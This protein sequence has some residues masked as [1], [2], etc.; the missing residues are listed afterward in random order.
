MRTYTDGLKSDF[1]SYILRSSVPRGESPSRYQLY[2]EIIYT[3]DWR[4]YQSVSF[5]GGHT[6][7]VSVINREVLG[8]SGACSFRETLGVMLDK[9]RVLGSLDADLHLR[10]NAKSG[11]YSY[12]TVPANYLKGFHAAVSNYNG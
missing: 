8:C 2:I 7:D 3:G 10:F 4:Y 11:D 12:I 1:H 9:E 5:E 6:E